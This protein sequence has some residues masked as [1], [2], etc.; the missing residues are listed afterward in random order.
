MR[1]TTGMSISGKM[2]VAMLLSASGVASTMSIAITMNVSGRRSATSTTENPAADRMGVGV[3]P[4]VYRSSG[5]ASGADI[6]QHRRHGLLPIRERDVQGIH[7]RR[8]IRRGDIGAVGDQQP[9][10]I[11]APIPRLEHDRR[12]A[13]L[14]RLVDPRPG[15][16]EP[17]RD[18]RLR[19]ERP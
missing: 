7:L 18:L 10:D 13:V 9:H 3:M 15:L 12:V 1:L 6:A 8:R 5:A 16:E 19:G 4:R 2:S 14:V 11:D 17:L